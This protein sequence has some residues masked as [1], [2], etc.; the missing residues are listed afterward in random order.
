M[1]S[2]SAAS[3]N[4]K[5]VADTLVQAVEAA[6]CTFSLIWGFCPGTQTR[7]PSVALVSAVIVL[8]PGF[9]DSLRASQIRIAANVVGALVGMTVGMTT[10]SS[11]APQ[12]ALALALVVVICHWPPLDKGVRSRA[13][14]GVVIVMMHEGSVRFDGAGASRGGSGGLPRRADGGLRWRQ[15]QPPAASPRLAVIEHG[16]TYEGQ[17]GR[18]TQAPMHFPGDLE[19]GLMV[20]EINLGVQGNQGEVKLLQPFILFG[21]HK[22]VLCRSWRS[23]RRK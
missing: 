10:G 1:T 7:A 21:D 20:T 15:T 9:E 22:Q 4:R 18:A 5:R 3:F 16:M 19:S 12:I 23:G 11:G 8:R 13:C 17:S 2:S 14:A 6:V